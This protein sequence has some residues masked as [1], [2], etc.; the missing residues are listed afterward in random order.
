[1]EWI[2]SWNSHDLDRILNHYADDVEV[3]SPLVET[4]LGPG[5]GVGARQGAAPGV[6]GHRP[7]QVPRS[8][9]P[10]LSRLRR[11]PQPGAPLRERAGSRRR[12][13]PGVR[14]GRAACAAYSPTMLSDRTPP[15]PELLVC[16]LAGT[17]V[18]DRGEVPAAFAAALTE[19][20]VPFNPDEIVAWR[21]AS[22][23]EVIGRLLARQGGTEA[24]SASR[25]PQVYDRFRTL[26]ADRL[27]QAGSLSLPGVREAFERL[28]RRGIRLALTT[29][30]DRGL[31]ETILGS[32]RVGPP[33]RR[34]GLR[35][36][37]LCGAPG[38][39]HDLPR[40]GAVWSGQRPTRRGGG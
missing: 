23:R 24:A 1:M 32:R 35:R 27:G 14:R 3:V 25:L 13:V 5:R 22:K 6:L 8:P 19:A 10:P 12:R 37:C 26:L 39:V 40:N 18:Y 20:E 11:R 31:V 15:P 16:D 17:T 7:G 30:F 4:V 34:L 29:G 28:R 2:A 9:F 38:A 36:R 21:G 33:A